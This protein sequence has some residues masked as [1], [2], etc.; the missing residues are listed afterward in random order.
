[1]IDTSGVS[2]SDLFGY[3]WIVAL[4]DD[5]ADVSS[6]GTPPSTAAGAATT[7]FGALCTALSSA[8]RGLLLH[9]SRILD[10]R[11]EQTAAF[12]AFY[13]AAPAAGCASANAA[14]PEMLLRRIA[15]REETLP[16]PTTALQTP[17]SA[18]AVAA[19]AAALDRGLPVL[20]GPFDPRRFE[21][22]VLR[23]LAPLISKSISP[24]AAAIPVLP[25]RA[26]AA[27]SVPA[28]QPAAPLA[29]AAAAS[30]VAWAVSGPRR[31]VAAGSGACT[32]TTA[33]T[34]DEVPRA[35]A[36]DNKWSK[37]EAA[38][39]G[40]AARGA[41][42]AKPPESAV[43]VATTTTARGLDLARPKKLADTTNERDDEDVFEF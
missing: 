7:S 10:R 22:G 19:V 23:V 2:E 12:R 37:T 9:S 29:P 35:R 33:A 43:M 17:P 25:R 1:M 28:A 40:A 34:V 8:G 20:E 24:P 4:P 39:A 6:D 15:G 5:D 42:S 27:A 16:R 30:S 36:A 26:A 14:P 3:P 13:F 21:R 18:E 31:G 38:A 41:R 11:G 32:T